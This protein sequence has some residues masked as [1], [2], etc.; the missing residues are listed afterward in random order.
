MAPTTTRQSWSSSFR[1]SSDEP[2]WNFEL[3]LTL[4]LTTGT[5]NKKGAQK[6]CQEAVRDSRVVP[7]ANIKRRSLC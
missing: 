2:V 7:G 1:T 4:T 5:E 6:A 3:L